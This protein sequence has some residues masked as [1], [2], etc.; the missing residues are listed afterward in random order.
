MMM[1]ISESAGFVTKTH[2]IIC[3]QS[4]DSVSTCPK[5]NLIKLTF[6]RDKQF[7]ISSFCGI[8]LRAVSYKFYYKLG[9]EKN[10]T[11]IN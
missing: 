2:I 9:I 8:F 6:A 4:N 3:F 11:A 5:I 10:Y 1:M 7:L